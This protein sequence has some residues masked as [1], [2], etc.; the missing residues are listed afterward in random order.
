MGFGASRQEDPQVSQIN[1]FQHVL[2]QRK[3]A[4]DWAM[5]AR[6]AGWGDV[7]WLKELTVHSEDRGL[8]LLLPC[9]HQVGMAAAGN[10]STREAETAR[11]GWLA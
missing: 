5:V 10:L 2:A 8:N 3:K 9:K 6:K 11:A 7:P 4:F 1:F